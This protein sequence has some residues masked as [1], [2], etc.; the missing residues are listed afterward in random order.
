MSRSLLKAAAVMALGAVWCQPAEALDFNFRVAAWN[1]S[2]SPAGS[3][4]M[5]IFPASGTSVYRA[6]VMF[7]RGTIPT[8]RIVYD[9]TSRIV[10]FHYGIAEFPVVSN[11]LEQSVSTF[12]NFSDVSG[13]A[14]AYLYTNHAP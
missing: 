4:T 8:P 12:V 6:S 2:H 11:L 3:V 5:Q 9:A 13:T 14:Y 7:H 1:T 10:T